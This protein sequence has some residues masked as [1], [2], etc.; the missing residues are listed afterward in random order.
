MRMAAPIQELIRAL[1]L[2]WKNLAAYPPG[3]P[4][5]V[6]ALAQLQRQLD[7]SRGPAG[8]LVFGIAADGLLWSGEKIETPQAQK[9]AQ[10]LYTR[11]VALLRFDTDTDSRDLETFLRLLGVGTQESKRPIWEELTA[12]GVL[13][14]VLEP[15]DYS[16]VQVTDSLDAPQRAIEPVAS[17]WDEI[18]RA[19]MLGNRM[20]A[21]GAAAHHVTSMDQLSALLNHYVEGSGIET[22]FDPEKTFGVNVVRVPETAEA[23]TRRVAEAIG[24]YVG[25]S[26]GLRREFALGQIAQLLRTLPESLRAAVIRSVLRVLATDESAGALLRELTMPLSR[27]EIL[28]ALRA[29]SGATRLSTHATMLLQSIVA[30]APKKERAALPPDVLTELAELFGEED[31]DRFNPPD[32]AALLEDVAIEIPRPTIDADASPDRLGDRVASVSEETVNRQVAETALDLLA[33]YGSQRASHALLLRVESA[34]RTALDTARFRDG[35]ELVQRL[36][37]IAAAAES[38]AFR[39]AVR[40]SLAR[41]ATPE[42]IH[43]LINGLQSAPPG[44]TALIQKLID[45]MGTAAAQN[46]LVAL[47]EESNRSRRRRLFDFICSLGASI[48]PVATSFLTDERWYVV[49]NMIVLLRT[50]GDR[51][52]LP[53]IGRC[54]RHPDLRVRL[55]AIK[56]LLAFDPAVSSALLE[57]AI[58]DPDPKL[59]ETA[60]TLVASYGIREGVRPLLR[61]LDGNDVFGRKRT[62]RLKAIKALGELADPAALAPMERFFADPFLPWPVRDERLAVYESLAGYPADARR[63]FVETGL[64]SRDAQIRTICLSLAPKGNA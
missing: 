14:I 12:A 64:A 34:F 17:L 53:A 11:G 46:L 19:L 24:N 50:V 6:S 42:T 4:I 16:S 36:R 10:A 57:E 45:A 2:G 35:I 29:L 18:L 5:L 23:V 37:E 13:H 21:A 7:A 61:I 40:E 38:E 30:T 20:S 43:S 39:D 8:E 28:D 22:T 55:E 41:L 63:R 58:N 33:K 1:A 27:D 44:T 60:I 26:S 48:V 31:I 9:L 32:H 15:V 59:A 51:T 52:S 62:L 3:H 47:A 49:R 54:A 56:T 25:N